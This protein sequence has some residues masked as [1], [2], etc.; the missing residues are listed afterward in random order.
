MRALARIILVVVVFG[1]G[2][3]AARAG[4]YNSLELK[5]PI[6][7]NYKLIKLTLS[8]IRSAHVLINRG[9]GKPKP[10]DYWGQV[11]T[12]VKELE[13][14]EAL[15]AISMVERADLGA[16]YVRLGRLD[17]A[18]QVLEAGLKQAAP[19]EPAR[20][21]LL[22][23][24]AVAYYNLGFLDRAVEYQ[25]QALAAWPERFPGWS[26]AE[27]TFYRRVD[28]FYFVLLTERFRESQRDDGRG[29]VTSPDNLFPGVSFV[30][31]G[32]KYQAGR[33]DPVA[34]DRLPPDAPHIV[35]MLLIWMPFDSRLLWLFAELL[36]S[37]GEVVNA[38]GIMDELVNSGLDIKDLREHRLVLREGKEEYE[39]FLKTKGAWHYLL[40]MLASTQDPWPAL[41][42]DMQV[43]LT[44]PKMNVTPPPPPEG[45]TGLPDWRVFTVG[46]VSGWL[47]SI[48]VALQ[49]RERR[50]RSHP[51]ARQ[52]A[53]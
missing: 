39:T 51:A 35:T 40:G 6:T 31:L 46:F 16:Y 23:N 14:R 13:P 33:I 21:L 10:E 17:R 15:G 9:Q 20:F 52:L 12:Q 38:L 34:Y 4:L 22:S 8:S 43:L 18:L 36:N 42:Q 11:L 48:L 44:E 32:E 49:W 27:I 1:G 24:L 45:R 28:R 47:V 5:M 41:A 25:R 29:L 37:R 7:T 50:R 19:D 3:T 53:G 26:Q 30:G 2:S